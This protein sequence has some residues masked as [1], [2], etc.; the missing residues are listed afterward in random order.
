MPQLI[1]S[2][3]AYLALK[4]AQKIYSKATAALQPEEFERVQDL[5]QKQHDL[6]TRVLAAAEARDVMVPPYS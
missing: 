3:V 4:A 6:E 5:A 1:E 2:G